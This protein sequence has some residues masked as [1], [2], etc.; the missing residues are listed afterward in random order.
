MQSLVLTALL[1]LIIIYHYAIIGYLH[2][3]EHFVVDIDD[4]EGDA[5]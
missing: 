2:F 4:D 3:P 5:G 1:A